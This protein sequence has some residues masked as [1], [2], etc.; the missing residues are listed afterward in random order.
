[1]LNNGLIEGNNKKAL[2]KGRWSRGSH[3]L[4][5]GTSAMCGKNWHSHRFNLLCDCV[6]HQETEPKQETRK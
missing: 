6:C 3:D 2:R 1:M 4:K 5:L